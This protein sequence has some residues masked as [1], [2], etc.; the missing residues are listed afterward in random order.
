MKQAALMRA[1]FEAESDM[2]CALCGKPYDPLDVFNRGWGWH[3]G[4]VLCDVCYL[5]VV[6]M[7]ERIHNARKSRNSK[8][9][10]VKAGNNE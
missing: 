8:S 9:D 4:R 5:N 1:F 2:K 7:E 6:K 10:N 3:L